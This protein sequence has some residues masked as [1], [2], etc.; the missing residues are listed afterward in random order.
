MGSGQSRRQSRVCNS[1]HH[2]VAGSCDGVVAIHQ[3]H[4]D[5]T[6]TYAQGHATH[7]LLLLL[8]L[9]ALHHREQVCKGLAAASVRC[10]KEAASIGEGWQGQRLQREQQRRIFLCAPTAVVFPEALIRD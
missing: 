4:A 6:V 7:L 8:Q 10:K 5:T 3:V 2:R 9:E 1:R